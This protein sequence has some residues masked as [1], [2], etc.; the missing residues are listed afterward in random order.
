MKYIN[1]CGVAELMS[2]L[3]FIEFCV[4]ISA[5]QVQR[6]LNKLC[7]FSNSCNT[8]I[9]SNL[10]SINQRN[11]KHK[12]LCISRCRTHIPIWVQGKMDGHHLKILKFTAVPYIFCKIPVGNIY[13][14][15]MG[16]C[17]IILFRKHPGGCQ[18]E[19]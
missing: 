3:F 2:S 4:Q 12:P 5:V 13:L 8:L 7:L 10:V 16:T 6:E 19:I 14:A 18:H 11:I 1:S 15:G 9:T 17:L